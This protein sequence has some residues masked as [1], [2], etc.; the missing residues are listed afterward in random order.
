MSYSSSKFGAQIYMEITCVQGCGKRTVSRE[1]ESSP[2][3]FADSKPNGSSR[4]S[5]V[6]CSIWVRGFSSLPVFTRK[7]SLRLSPIECCSI[8]IREG[9][10]YQVMLSRMF[11]SHTDESCR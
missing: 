4:V 9:E 5:A 3:G 10:S 2:S 6:H 11:M 8:Y 7:T 1:R